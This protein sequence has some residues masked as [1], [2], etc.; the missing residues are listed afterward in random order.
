MT[1]FACLSKKV[2]YSFCLILLMGTTAYSQYNTVV[3]VNGSGSFTTIQAAINAAP[4][5]QTTPYVIFIKKGKYR[6]VVTIPSSKP[7]IQLIG[8]SMAETIIS[9]DNYSGKPNPAGSTYGTSTSA[10]VFVSASDCMLMNLSI[11]NATGYGVDANAIPPA[12]GDGPQALALNVSADRVVFY[13]CRF[14]GGQDTLFAGGGAGKRNYF[15]NCYIDGNTDFIFG[16]A[17]VIFDTCVIYPRTRLDK[18]TGGYV[19]AANTKARSGYGYVFRDC[20]LSKNRGSTNYTLGRPWQSGSGGTYNKTVF[21]N[22]SMGSNIS[23]VGWSVFDANTTPATV[24][25]AEYNSTHYDASAVDVSKRISWS[26]QLS[27]SEAAKYY[28]NDTVFL[29]ADTIPLRPWN[30]VASWPVI[31]A[32]PFVPEI[33]ISNLLARK[34]GNNTS[35]TW[36]ITFPMPDVTCDLYKSADGKNYSFVSSFLSKEDTACNFS[37][38][39]SSLPAAGTNFYYLIKASKSGLTSITSDTGVISSTPKLV[40]SGNLSNIIQGV[41]VPSD[42][43]TYQL[44][45]SNLINNVIVTPP[46]PFEVTLDTTTTWY[47]HDNPLVIVPTGNA[48]PATTVFV[49]INGKTPGVYIDSIYHSTVGGNTVPLRVKGTMLSIPL[50]HDSYTLIQWPLTASSDDKASVRA[51][52]IVPSVPTFSSM[53]SAAT[54]AYSAKGIGFANDA[55]VGKWSVPAT[56]NRGCYYQFSVVADSSHQIRID[57]IVFST[58]VQST[59][60]GSVAVQYSK[61]GFVNDSADIS[62]GIGTTGLGLPATNYGAYA[63]PAAVSKLAGNNDSTLRF[64]ADS[65]IIINPKDTLTIR[66]YYGVGSTNTPRYAYLKNVIIK[67]HPTEVVLPLNLLSFAATNKQGATTLSWSTSNE[68]A[69][70]FFYVEK[71]NDG[72]NFSL[73]STVKST[74]SVGLN[75]Y[76]AIDNAAQKGTAYYRLKMT[77]RDGKFVYSKILK[78]SVATKAIALY[79]IYPNPVKSE[80]TVTVNDA[81]SSKHAE[82][83]TLAGKKVLD[84]SLEKGA[85]LKKVAVSKLAKGQ[86]LFVV[87]AENGD[88]S[89]QQ[90][91]KD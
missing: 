68:I 60:N 69:T 21:L 72:I 25:Y 9:Y 56:L 29:N 4:S 51:A 81:S 43:S 52:G 90:F 83:L 17:T 61:S 19:T 76:S 5:G 80:L 24:L 12:P 62:S 79:S 30:P 78:V 26:Y 71:S 20:K 3:D 59:F 66:L 67:G 8:E 75:S 65:S 74:N 46:V 33:S 63:F 77:D 31:A 22:T 86:Y 47:T 45:G 7:F 89:T 6:E 27:A 40:A 91:N 49:R 14:N 70:S 41:D 39:D 53:L 16:D 54:P 2:F 15:K 37:Y 32:K 84:V 42:P 87:R 57:S 58:S 10:T 88:V 50:L 55:T 85:S 1:Y 73:L 34:S 11:E 35:V 23:A 36:N 28:N 13:N 18:G 38:T 64:L 82:I 48:L 44:S